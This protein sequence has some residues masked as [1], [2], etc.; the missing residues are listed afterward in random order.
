MGLLG[1]GVKEDVRVAALYIHGDRP[2]R[3]EDDG[4]LPMLSMPEL[5]LVEGCGARQDPRYFRPPDPGR[6]RKRQVSVI[7]EE[8]IRRH[9]ERFGPIPWN[10]V[11]SQVVLAGDCALPDLIGRVIQFD[12]GPA[13]EV[14]VAR[15]P[16]FAM[17]FIHPGLKD[18]MESGRQGVLAMVVASGTLRRGHVGH[19]T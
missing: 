13:I 10:L 6:I 17:D 9:E 11:K 2:S 4:P 16:C 3:P 8:T 1:S 12:D 15:V 19:L 7:D 14:S 18:A 5:D